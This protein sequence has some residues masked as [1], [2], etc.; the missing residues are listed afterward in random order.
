LGTLKDSPP[1]ISNF[2]FNIDDFVSYLTTTLLLVIVIVIGNNDD[3][4]IEN[5]EAQVS[6]TSSISELIAQGNSLIELG[7]YEESIVWFDKALAIEPKNS[8]ALYNKAVALSDLGKHEEAIT[9]FDKVLDL[10]PNDTDALTYKGI[11]LESL[12]NHAA[13]IIYFDKVLALEPNNVN[14]LS[15]KEYTLRNMGKNEDMVTNLAQQE[16]STGNNTYLLTY[17]NTT[18]GIKLKY[19]AQWRVSESADVNS[20]DDFKDIVKFYSPS[21]DETKNR[22]TILIYQDMRPVKYSSNNLINEILKRAINEKRMFPNFTIIESIPENTSYTLTYTDNLI[23]P[24]RKVTEIGKVFDDRIFVIRYAAAPSNH[25]IYKN[26]LTELID[27]FEVKD[28]R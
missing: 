13:A 15:W 20:A 25:S 23:G 17:S 11:S 28:N 27:S 3:Y 22:F 26:F 16:Y 24:E 7:K 1:H 6:N 12:G 18:Y 2:P 5:V 4:R 8:E 19:P 21:V 10:D 14:T 9:Y